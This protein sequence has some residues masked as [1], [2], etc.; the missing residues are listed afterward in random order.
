MKTSSPT[1]TSKGENLYGSPTPNAPLKQG[2]GNAA[3]EYQGS[4]T[5]VDKANVLGTPIEIIQSK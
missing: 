1:K 5:K 2:Y 3:K 4:P